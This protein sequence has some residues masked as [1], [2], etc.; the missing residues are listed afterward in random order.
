MKKLFFIAVFLFSLPLFSNAATVLVETNVGKESINAV[1][2]ILV[3]PLNTQ[4]EEIYIG[5]SSVLIWLTE[6]VWDAKNHTV[7]FAGLSPGGFSGTVPLFALKLS[8]GEAKVAGGR[9]TGYR[10]DG[11]GTPLQ[12]E[13]AFRNKE[14]NPDT[15]FPEPFIILKS[16]SP[17]IFEGRKFITFLTQ[18]KGT[19][20]V[21]YEFAA[22]WLF[23]PDDTDFS[24]T[25]SPRALSTLE[26][27]KRLYVRA[28]DASGNHMTVSTGGPYW[29]LTLLFGLIILVCA[30]Q[31]LRR[32]FWRSS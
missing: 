26:L 32:S 5:E 6:P 3:L 1:E 22:T 17:E 31:F 2:G 21:K 7:S 15:E 16:S 29:F 28:T 19:G 25:E 9:L 11:E 23:P 30:L 13:Y 4:V 24:I 27:F 10:N 20:V 8:S 12:F 14:L 18:D